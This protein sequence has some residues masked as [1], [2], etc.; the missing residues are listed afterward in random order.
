[1]PP[2]PEITQLARTSLNAM[3]LANQQVGTLVMPAFLRN[4][5][6]AYD[7]RGDNAGSW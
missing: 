1:M 7:Y 4:R 6:R 5:Q 2:D 3:R